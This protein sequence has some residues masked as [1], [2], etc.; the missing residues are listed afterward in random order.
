LNAAA[1]AELVTGNLPRAEQLFKRVLP[2]LRA[3]RGY[4]DSEAGVETHLAFLQLRAGRRDEARTLLEESLAADQR[5]RNEG[6]RDWSVPYD[7]ACV[8]ALRGEK[9]QAY[10]WLDKA[11]EA[12]WRGWPLSTRSPLLDSLRGDPRFRQ[13]EPRLDTSVLQMRRRAGLN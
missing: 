3:T 6:N 12:G 4:R 13:L 9:D 5:A 11:V 7:T 10:R 1:T 8:H 2:L